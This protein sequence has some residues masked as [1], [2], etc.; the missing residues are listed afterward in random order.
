MYYLWE[1]TGGRTAV[2]YMGIGKE[3]FLWYVSKIKN[4]FRN[5]EKFSLTNKRSADIENKISSYLDGKIKSLNLKVKFLSGT[6]FQKKVWNT[7]VA[8]P[9][10]RTVSYKKLADI[11]GYG[12]AWRA[13]G[14]ALKKNPVILAV[15]CHRVINQNGSI[16][17][18]IAGKKVKKF[19]LDMEKQY[20]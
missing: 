2:L 19:L 17:K 7:A 14:S 20:G 10:G 18:S 5:P 3:A 15:P 13:V 4:N 1:Y 12:K 6:Q 16:S 11:S 9:Y 8:I